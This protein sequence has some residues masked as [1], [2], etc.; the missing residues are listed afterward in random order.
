MADF[1]YYTVEDIDNTRFYQ[2]PKILFEDER[3]IDL[4]DSAS[5]KIFNFTP[6]FN[7]GTNRSYGYVYVYRNGSS[8][9]S[10]SFNGNSTY[11]NTTVNLDKG[12]VY[13][14]TLEFRNSNSYVSNTTI[15]D[16]NETFEVKNLY[17]NNGTTIDISNFTQDPDNYNVNFKYNSSFCVSSLYLRIF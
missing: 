11:N 17:L 8:I 4:T 2:M 12:Y 10:G 14:V 7:N 5:D 6:T 9:Y 16:L 1:K 3:F 13:N 15:N